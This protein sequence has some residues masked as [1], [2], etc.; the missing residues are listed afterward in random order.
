ME[1]MKAELNLEELKKVVGGADQGKKTVDFNAL[2]TLIQEIIGILEFR[3]EVAEAKAAAQACN[4]ACNDKNLAN[5]KTNY[6]T[7]KR[8]FPG[9]EQ[10]K[11][12]DRLLK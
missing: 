5:F 6:Q 8:K 7:L 12:I 2:Q 11:E 1:N 3:D 10:Y 4:Q 9:R